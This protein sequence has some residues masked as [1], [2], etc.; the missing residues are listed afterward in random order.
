[1]IFI[2]HFLSHFNN[3]KSSTI[4][5]KQQKHINVNINSKFFNKSFD[6]TILFSLFFYINFSNFKVLSITQTNIN[7]KHIKKLIPQPVNYESGNLIG[8]SGRIR[9]AGLSLRAKTYNILKAQF[10]DA[11]NP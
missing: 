8:V 10:H 4:N 1:M 3:F 6:K 9:T 5:S 11:E 7:K 2:T